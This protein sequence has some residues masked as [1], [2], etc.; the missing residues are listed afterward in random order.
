MMIVR[1]SKIILNN[2]IFCRQNTI[3][4]TRQSRPCRVDDIVRLKGLTNKNQRQEER[5]GH[6]KTSFVFQLFLSKLSALAQL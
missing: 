3:I 1:A 4:L 6:K 2:W 5:Q